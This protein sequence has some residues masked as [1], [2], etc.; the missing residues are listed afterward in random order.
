MVERVTIT[1]VRPNLITMIDGIRLTKRPNQLDIH[2]R[3]KGGKKEKGA[4]TKA[5]KNLLDRIKQIVVR[6]RVRKVDSG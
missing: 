5:H 4:R 3:T 1:A 6:V 2:W